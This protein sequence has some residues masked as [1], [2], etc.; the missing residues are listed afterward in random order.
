MAVSVWRD[1]DDF[2]NAPYRS[3]P[4]LRRCLSGDLVPND[5]YRRDW[6]EHEFQREFHNF[7]WG[8]HHWDPQY[9]AVS[10]EGFRVTV[11]LRDYLPHEI[12]V[13]TNDY[14]VIIQA[15]HSERKGYDHYVTRRFTR[16][17]TIP[18]ECDP[19][20]I[21]SELSPY[22]YLTIKCPRLI[23]SK[24]IERYVNVKRVKFDV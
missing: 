19:S 21:T 9:P 8:L 24:S 18:S 23:R 16:R 22:G 17:Y 10:R 1:L 6:L 13:K 14:E 20:R 7:E 4:T 11:D 5:W 2:L 12:T 15:E 3:H